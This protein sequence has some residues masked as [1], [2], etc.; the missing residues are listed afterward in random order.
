[1]SGVRR[2]RIEGED[3]S[4]ECREDDRRDDHP[5]VSHRREQF[6]RLMIPFHCL[7]LVMLVMVSGR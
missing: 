7:L 4:R 5:R 2:R 1:L 6:V 3:R